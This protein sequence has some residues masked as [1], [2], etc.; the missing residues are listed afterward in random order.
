LFTACMSALL[1]Q[2]VFGNN[3]TQFEPRFAAKALL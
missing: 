3:L 2:V 1:V